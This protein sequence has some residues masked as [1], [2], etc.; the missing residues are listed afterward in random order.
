MQAQIER[1]S[2]DPPAKKGAHPNVPDQ[3]KGSVNITQK[4]VRFKVADSCK[5]SEN[6]LLDTHRDALPDAPEAMLGPA[7]DA[8]DTSSSCGS[9]ADTSTTADSSSN[10]APPVSGRATHEPSCDAPGHESMQWHEPSVKDGGASKLHVEP[11]MVPISTC[12]AAELFAD[13]NDAPVGWSDID[14]FTSHTRSS[15]P[16]SSRLASP[17]S[18][19][20]NMSTARKGECPKPHLVQ[21]ENQLRNETEPFNLQE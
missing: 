2:T 15:V 4:N 10:C 5:E 18:M 20:F 7:S 13:H 19:S 17:P 9:A 8:M 6:S 11:P 21:Y 16:Q 14:F 3:S 1:V 12:P